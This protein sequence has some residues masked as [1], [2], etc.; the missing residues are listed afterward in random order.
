M[1]HRELG[2]GLHFLVGGLIAINLV[3]CICLKNYLAIFGW[4]V[5]LMEWTKNLMDV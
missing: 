1:N 5:A 3:L 4:A 2:I